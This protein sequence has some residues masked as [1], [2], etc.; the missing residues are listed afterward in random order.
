MHCRSGDS[1]AEWLGAFFL[2]D[3]WRGEPK[4]LERKHGDLA[5]HD[6]KH[7]PQDVIPYTAQGIQCAL[8]GVQYSDFGWEKG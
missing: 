2:A 1:G 5:W 3:S 6:P 7:L 4:L 8:D